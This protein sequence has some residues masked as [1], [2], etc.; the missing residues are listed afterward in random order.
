MGANGYRNTE[1]VA[2]GEWYL[3]NLRAVYFTINIIHSITDIC[4]NNNI[5]LLIKVLE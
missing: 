5:C 3:T 2:N 4:L 1:Y